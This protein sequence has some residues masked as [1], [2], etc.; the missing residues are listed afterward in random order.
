MYPTIE[1]TL[2]EADQQDWWRLNN[3]SFSDLNDIDNDGVQNDEDLDDDGDGLIEIRM[4]DMFNNM[5][6]VLNGTGYSDGGVSINATGC[7]G[8]CKG[9]ELMGDIDLSGSNWMPIGGPGCEGSPFAAV[10]EGN[11]HTIKDLTIN[12]PNE[13]CVGLFSSLEPD[14]IIRNVR[15]SVRGI[16][17]ANKTGGLVGLARGARIHSSRVTLLDGNEING[18]NKTGGLVGSAEGARISS[19]G[20]SIE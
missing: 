9:Y 11:R 20:V 19:S 3:A 6:Y 13:S 18:A 16:N 10:F 1:C 4:A 5:R 12:R 15:L 2:D 14:A 17:G 8:D 7:G